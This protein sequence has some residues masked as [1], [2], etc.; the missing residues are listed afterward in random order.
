[1]MVLITTWYPP[2]KAPEAAK[3]YIEMRQKIPLESFEKYLALGVSSG[4]EGIKAITVMDV[5]KG[6]YEESIRQ[7]KKEHRPPLN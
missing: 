4:K 3:R 2:D 5:E 1:M 6:K 7:Q